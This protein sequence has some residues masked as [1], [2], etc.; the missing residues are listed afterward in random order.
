MRDE[1][2]LAALWFPSL[3]IWAIAF[4]KVTRC[5]QTWNL[6]SFLVPVLLLHHGA[7]V[8]FSL[9]TTEIRDGIS[10]PDVVTERWLAALA[11]MYVFL[12]IGALVANK[13]WLNRPNAFPVGTESFSRPDANILFRLLVLAT[14]A[15][16]VYQLYEFGVPDSLVSILLFSSTFDDYT[17]QRLGF[18][19]FTGSRV[20]LGN[21]LIAVAG[22]TVI[23]VALSYS[24]ICARRS[25]LHAAVFALLFAISA[26][27]ALVSGHKSLV[28]LLVVGTFIAYHIAH[29]G[30]RLRF[31]GSAI[32]VG[33]GSVLV[34]VP[35]LFLMQYEDFSYWDGLYSTFFRVCIEP[36][37]A[38][39]TFLFIYPD[40]FPFRG[41]TS[42]PLVANLLGESDAIPPHTLIPLTFGVSDTTW[43]IGYIGDAW[44]DFGWAGIIGQSLL[45]GLSLQWLNLWFHTRLASAFGLAIYIALIVTAHRFAQVSMLSTLAGF[46]FFPI[47]LLYVLGTRRRVRRFSHLVLK[48]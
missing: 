38:L 1:L 2:I 11:L 31:R 4:N 12:L 15:A 14:V 23:P 17:E 34:L 36:N 46:G 5:F 9:T 18:G 6:F 26:Y 25:P 39:Q 22:Y 19:E 33:L 10:L 3:F 20:G 37:R 47:L 16:T 41:G 48:P 7:G 45:L 21:Y 13:T 30:F 8:P 42:S 35:L 44:A 32:A 28:L 24:L 29:N 27:R 40:S 43:N